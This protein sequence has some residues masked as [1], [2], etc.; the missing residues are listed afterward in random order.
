MSVDHVTVEAFVEKD[1]PI[2][3]V[4]AAHWRTLVWL[5]AELLWMFAHHTHIAGDLNATPLMPL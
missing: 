2:L 3:V 5:H 4:P 1:E